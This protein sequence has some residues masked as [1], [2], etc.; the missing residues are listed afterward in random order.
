MLFTPENERRNNERVSTTLTATVKAKEDSINSW[1]ENT[2]VLSISKTGAGFFL[3]R[4]CTIGQLLSLLLPMPRNLRAYDAD[5]EL[6]RVWG[7]V[8]YCTPAFGKEESSE[9]KFH[10]GVAFVGRTPPEDYHQNPRQTYRISGMSED[11]LWRIEKSASQFVNRKHHRIWQN[12]RVS[13]LHSSED[14]N[15][16]IFSGYTENIS[17]SGAS[18]ISNLSV[19]VGDCVEFECENPLFNTVAIVRNHKE[20][21]GNYNRI[22]L[23]F[24]DNQFPVEALSSDVEEEPKT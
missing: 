3:P 7:L 14:G 8:Q 1:I 4:Q 18:V 13:L 22:H 17:L 20:S 9:P 21:S 11:G 5:K 2:S 6:F 16:D 19:N 24:I 10:V 12:L 23:E 15:P